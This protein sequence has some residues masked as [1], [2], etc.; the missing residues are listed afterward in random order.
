MPDPP[1]HDP[2]SRMNLPGRPAASAAQW[3]TYVGLLAVVCLFCAPLFVGLSGWDLENDE[4]IYSYA[5]DYS[6]LDPRVVLRGGLALSRSEVIIV[7]PGQFRPCIASAVASGA[8]EVRSSRRT[9][10]R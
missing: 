6:K 2:R 9:G 7:A 4:A 8:T 10:S 5:V 3:S 1:P